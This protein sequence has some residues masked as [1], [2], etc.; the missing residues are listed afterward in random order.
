[1][2]QVGWSLLMKFRLGLLVLELAT[3]PSKCKMVSGVLHVL[4]YNDL[5]VL[6]STEV[7]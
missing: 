4:A 7:H 5:E 1:M 2:T 6:C 3:G